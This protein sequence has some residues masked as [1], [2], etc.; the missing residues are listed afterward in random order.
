MKLNLGCGMNKKDGFINID[1]YPEGDPDQLMD[2]EQFPWAFDD[3]SIDEILLNHVLE[4]LGQETEVFF[5]IMK[6][7]YRICKDGATIQVNVPHPRHDNFIHDPTH[8]RV[9]TPEL[10]GL[11][12]KEKCLKWKESGASNSPLGLYLDVNFKIETLRIT[13]ENEY[14]E[15]INT[16]RLTEAQVMDL[17]RKQNNVASEYCI[18]LKAV[19]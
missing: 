1:K 6:E 11:F 14:L 9:I 5:S 17:M 4:H 13:L 7:M 2:L 10:L 18:T 19:K 15:A 16:G 8:V 3:N 12:D